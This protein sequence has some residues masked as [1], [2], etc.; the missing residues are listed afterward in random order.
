MSQQVPEPRDLSDDTQ[1]PR[2]GEQPRGQVLIIFAFLLTILLGMAAFVVD[3]AWIWSNQLQVQRAADAGALAGVVHLPADPSGGIAAARAEARKNG[4]EHN[5]DAQ[6]AASPDPSFS[7]RMIVTISAPVE[8][9]FMGL[10]GFDEVT[11]TRT[12]RAEYI[13]PVPMG[14]P[15]NYLGVG[16]FTDAVTTTVTVPISDTGDTDY[17]NRAEDVSGNW[18]D[19]EDVDENDGRDSEADSNNDANIWDDFGLQSGGDGVPN[20]SG[21]TIQQIRVRLND[22]RMDDDDNSGCSVRVEI[23]TQSPSFWS[24]AITQQLTSDNDND[25]VIG[26]SSGGQPGTTPWGNHTW[27]YSDFGDGNF[28]VRLTWLEPNNCSGR[29]VELDE[30]EVRVNWRYDTTQTTTTTTIQDVD[31]RDPYGQAVLFPQRFWAGMQ[32]QGA[33]ARQGDAFMTQYDPPGDSSPRTSAGNSTYCPFANFCTPHPEGYYN[34]AIEIP[35]G[36]G[37]VWI[38]DPGFCDV[39]SEEGTRENWTT[40]GSNSGSIND[41]SAF[42]RLY[43]TS[44]TAWDFNDDVRVDTQSGTFLNGD[45]QPNTF[46]RGFNNNGERYADPLLTNVSNL[47]GSSSDY[48]NCRTTSGMSHNAWWRIASGLPAGTYRLHT[49]SHDRIL[50][51]DQSNTTALN[52]FAIWASA[53]GATNIN[54]VRVYGLGAMEAYFPLDPGV[55]SRFYLAQIEAVHANKWVDISLWD[56]GD[57][58]P[59][60]ADL[61][62]LMPTASGYQAVPFYFN[63]SPGTTLPTDFSCGPETSSQVSSI[64]THNGGSGGGIYNGDWLRLCF[65]LPAN[66][67]AP[68]PPADALTPPQGVEGGWFRIQY[69]MGGGSDNATDLTTWKVEVRGNPVHL[70]TPG[71]DVPTP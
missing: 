12:A 60:R 45:S 55:T 1:G 61:S 7:R 47:P 3:L 52:A 18:D 62:I 54:D 69:A 11:V 64:R 49:T 43:N 21:L 70:I 16:D 68:I 19:P 14:S 71:D 46:R 26:A 35:S 15:Q 67:S 8:T 44:D 23:G 25:F 20:Q 37:E 66:W 53:G 10:F 63:S 57:T 38:F 4:Y 27:V 58:N 65:Q 36:A 24:T 9:F 50:P 30:L 39:G 33:P 32:S 13:L 6:I 28:R 56:P 48:E 34:Y 2:R 31:I 59:L 42:Y 40:S 29:E 41:V 5:V 22:I 51:S 17:R